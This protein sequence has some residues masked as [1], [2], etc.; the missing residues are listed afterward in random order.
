VIRSIMGSVIVWSAIV[1]LPVAGA[2]SGR[3]A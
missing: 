3:R 2:D 1:S